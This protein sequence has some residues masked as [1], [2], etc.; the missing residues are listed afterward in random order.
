MNPIDDLK[1]ETV[2][3]ACVACEGYCDRVAVTE[4]EEKEHGCGTK[5]C[6]SR[7]FVCRVCGKRYA[8]TCD[9]PDK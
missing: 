8:G 1:R 5:R 4:A 6:C 9:A 2:G 7:A 3:I